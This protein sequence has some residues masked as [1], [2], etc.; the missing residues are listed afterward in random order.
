M[1]LLAEAVT[2]DAGAMALILAILALGAALTIAAI[3]LG[4]IWAD[5]AGKGSARALVG[6]LLIAAVEALVSVGGI[7]SLLDDPNPLYLFPLAVLGYQLWLY[8]RARSGRSTTGS[9]G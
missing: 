4:C 3:V 7:A 5:R 8:L 2:L 1:M 9:G 6:W